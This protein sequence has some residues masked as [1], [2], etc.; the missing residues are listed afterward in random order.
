[1]VILFKIILF[2]T[3]N[4]YVI[5]IDSPL[6]SLHWPREGKQDCVAEVWLEAD[7]PIDQLKVSKSINSI[8]NNGFNENKLKNLKV[9]KE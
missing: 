4:I 3:R 5:S 7:V 2:P 1:M 6:S 9:N 8:N